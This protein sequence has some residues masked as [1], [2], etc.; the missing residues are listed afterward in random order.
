LPPAQP[1]R[2]TA[3]FL[4]AFGRL[5]IPVANAGIQRD[6]AIESMTLEAREKVLAVDL[7]GQFLC[8]RAAL[9]CFARQGS[10]SIS[11]APPARSSA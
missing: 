4:D 11:R 6:A 7:T 3:V 8:A 2:R 5:D 1:R 9:R 10:T